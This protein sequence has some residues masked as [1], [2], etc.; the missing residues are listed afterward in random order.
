MGPQG[1]KDAL[2]GA[3]L[4]GGRVSLADPGV[5]H[6]LVWVALCRVKLG[7]QRSLSQGQDTWKQERLPGGD[8]GTGPKGPGG[9]CEPGRETGRDSRRK[10][11]RGGPL[12][13]VMRS[14]VSGLFS[15][16]ETMSNAV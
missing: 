14:S 1:L 6:Y 16:W 5:W 15:G 9:C 2:I 4:L 11:P 8:A 12:A 7:A 3:Y 10:E 13:G